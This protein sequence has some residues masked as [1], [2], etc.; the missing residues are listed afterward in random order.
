MTCC[1]TDGQSCMR[2]STIL[3]DGQLAFA[4]LVAGYRRWSNFCVYWS[5]DQHYIIKPGGKYQLLKDGQ[6]D[7]LLE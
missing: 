7:L 2:I 3:I 5:Y 6:A 4:R 1:P